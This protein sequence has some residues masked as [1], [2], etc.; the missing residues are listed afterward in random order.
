MLSDCPLRD[1]SLLN[2]QSATETAKWFQLKSWAI[3]PNSSL[4][5]WD[6]S[7]MILHSSE[8]AWTHPHERTPQPIDRIDL[9]SYRGA[10][11][12]SPTLLRS[13][14]EVDDTNFI[15]IAKLVKGARQ[16]SVRLTPPGFPT[17]R[18]ERV[19]PWQAPWKHTLGMAQTH[20]AIRVRALE[21]R[22][23]LSDLGYRSVS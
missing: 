18:S 12:F 13:A 15:V 9:R 23:S 1:R 19:E 4:L 20:R 11:W 21:R 2:V 5:L 14:G 10:T 8:R 3:A 22:A 16:P 7:S 17:P 6:K